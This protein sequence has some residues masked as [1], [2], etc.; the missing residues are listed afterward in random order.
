MALLMLLLA[1]PAMADPLPVLTGQMF[2]GNFGEGVR[3]QITTA[4]FSGF[5]FDTG[6]D[7][8]GDM[9]PPGSLLVYRAH[10]EGGMGQWTYQGITYLCSSGLGCR[11]EGNPSNPIAIGFEEDATIL[12]TLPVAPFVGEL[13]GPATVT[14][15][16]HFGTDMFTYKGSGLGTVHV[17]YHSQ[18]DRFRV[19]S[20]T[21][22]F[23]DA[24]LAPEP[25][26]WA[27][28]L[29]GAAALWLWRRWHMPIASPPK[30]CAVI[31]LI[32][33]TTTTSDS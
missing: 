16:I 6:R 28:L 23:G 24:V 21:A 33:E 5:G 19:G 25:A 13:S 2:A 15:D 17:N 9:L 30:G 1:S 29:M 20:A 18:V 10:E 7:S 4:L 3:F 14:G 31:A 27:L 32:A 11:S 8:T 26:T 22:V 12:L